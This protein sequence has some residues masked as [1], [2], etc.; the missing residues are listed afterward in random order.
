M[1]IP[2]FCPNPACP[3]HLKAPGSPAW[4]SHRG[5]YLTKSAGKIRRFYCTCCKRGFSERTFSID[6]YTKKLVDYRKLLTLLSSSMGLRQISRFTSLSL[7]T[8]SNRY[9]RLSRQSLAL[10]ERISQTHEVGEDLVADEFETFSVS[11]YFPEF[12]HLLVGKDSQFLYFFT[13]MKFKRKGRMTEVQKLIKEVLYERV[14]FKRGRQSRS[15]AEV[16]EKIAQMGAHRE[17]LTLHTDEKKAYLTAIPRNPTLRRMSEEGR[18]IHETTV[19]TAPRTFSNPLFAVNYFDREIRKDSAGHVRETVRFNR[20]MSAG[21][22]RLSC[23]ALYHNFYK[24]FRIN[25]A[26]G[27]DRRHYREA[28]IDEELV[29]GRLAKIFTERVFISKE[30]ITGFSRRL[31]F[32]EIETPLKKRA[33]YVPKFAYA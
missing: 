19:S 14:K 17:C 7:A 32:K 8:L 26:V 12:Y 23:Y 11:Q 33:E 4:F 27:S 2:P 30:E 20:N 15:F 3:Y 13:H 5:S 18:F 10:H 29:K 25:D 21:L 24:C 28:E 9:E 1:F 22:I 31:W 6:Y 16:M